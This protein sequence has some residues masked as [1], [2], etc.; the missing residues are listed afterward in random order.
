VKELTYS[1]PDQNEQALCDLSFQVAKGECIGIIGANGSGKSTLCY[2][3]MGLVPHF[4]HGTIQGDVWIEGVN[5]PDADMGEMSKQ[6]GLVFQ[7]PINQFSGAKVT[8][9]DEIAF[10]LENLGFDR[11]T[12]VER[13]EWVTDLLGISALKDRNPYQLSGGQ[14]QRVAI[15][16]ILALKSQVVVLDEPTSQLDPFGTAEV[17]AAIDTLRAE[18]ITV[19]IVEHKVEL[20]VEHCSRLL[21]LMN[22][23]IKAF[24]VPDRV[25]SHPNV[26]GWGITIPKY[27]QAYRAIDQ[28]TKSVPTTLSETVERLNQYEL[29]NHR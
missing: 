25:F 10:G 5:V 28:G 19:V 4:Y 23:Q 7:N 2:A 1:Y 29:S 11:E 26:D 27:S 8:V 3:L 6:V 14:M 13:I 16:S 20:L 15:A 24:D 17:F 12:M 18:G 9:E 22:G 21:V